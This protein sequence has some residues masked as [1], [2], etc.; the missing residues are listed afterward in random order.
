MSDTLWAG[1]I[2]RV[3]L[4]RRRIRTEPTADYGF[5]LGGR[6]M[7]Q[8]ILFREVDPGVDALD[9][10]NIVTIGAGPLTGTMAPAS[11]RGTVDTQNAL[12]GGGCAPN[13]GRGLRPP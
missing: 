6:G 7:G 5:A 9:P 1:Q 13:G 4:T 12:T 2:R 8:W 11:A 3:D 10:E